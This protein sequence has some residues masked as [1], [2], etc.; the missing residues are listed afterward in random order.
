MGGVVVPQARQKD[1]LL[2]TVL[3]GMSIAKDVY[4]I[5]AQAD[6]SER[7]DQ[8][9]ERQNKAR[10]FSAQ[11]GITLPQK[12]DAEKTHTFSEQQTPGSTPVYIGTPDKNT[13][14]FATVREKSKDPQRKYAL[15]SGE[16]VQDGVKGK[17]TKYNDGTTDFIASP[18]DKPG[19]SKEASNAQDLR[20]EYNSHPVTKDT[21]QL[22]T[23]YKK[24]SAAAESKNPTGATDIS[25]VYSFMKMND[26]GST[27]REGEYATAENSGGI[28]PKLM[29]LYNKIVEG[30][31]LTPSQRADF[32]EASKSLLNGQLDLQNEQDDRYAALAKQFKVPAESIIDPTFAK[33]R[34]TLAKETPRAAPPGPGEAQAAAGGDRALPKP[35]TRIK[36]GGVLGTVAP[37]GIHFIPDDPENQPATPPQAPN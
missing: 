8:E 30:V 26:P 1:D 13:P 27:V 14:M 4:G 11:G 29:N 23:N 5:S 28:P 18:P 7:A 20:K 34:Q 32:H 37:D 33:L 17:I 2:T 31:R 12:L 16:T 21:V 25:L 6:A 19:E 10:E 15:S 3:K 9:Q 22:V 36:V 24:I 35:G